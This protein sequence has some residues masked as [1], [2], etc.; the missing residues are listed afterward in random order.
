MSP[1]LEERSSA[2]ERT[3][4]VGS[5]IL[6]GGTTAPIVVSEDG[7]QGRSCSCGVVYIDPLPEPGTVN[8]AEDR[9]MHTYYSLPAKLRLDWV[10]RFQP[11][12]RLLEVGCGSGEF[13]ALAKTRGY[14]IAA[15]EPNP[16][17]ARIAADSLGIEVEESLIEESN[18]PEQSYDVVFHVD[19]LSHFP[20]PVKALRKMARLVRPGGVVCFE[21]GIFG[22][23]KRS[24]Y[25]WVGRIGYPHHLWL[26]SESA[27]HA[28][29]ERAGLRVE[30]VR[31]FGLLPATILSTLGNH[32]LRR[33]ISRPSSDSG[34]APRATGF[35]LA[36][37]WFQYVLRYRI[38]AFVPAIGPHALFVAARPVEHFVT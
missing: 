16:I 27:V 24:W 33:K 3:D 26:Y 12:G 14:E 11:S 10:S 38:G 23:L 8:L 13:L 7:Y 22:G 31:R 17:S 21:V 19:L 18:L 20:D 5:C 15:V 6:C 28:V 34:R 25:P 1:L 37:S 4:R 29:L 32:T 30:A 2:L 35:Y 9:H 36:Y